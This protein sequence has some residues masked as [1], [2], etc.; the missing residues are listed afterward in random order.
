MESS[1]LPALYRSADTSSNR[2]QRR[3]FRV[4]CL[5]YCL[6]VL[7]A[8]LGEFR[9]VSEAIL[10]CMIIFIILLFGLLIYRFVSRL[11]RKWYACRALA[12]SV[13]TSA[14]KYSMRAHPFGDATTVQIPTNNFT[15]SLIEI[16]RDNALT[17][18]ELDAEHSDKE[19]ISNEMS[20]LRALGWKERLDVYLDKR[21]KQQRTWYKKKAQKNSKSRMFWFGFAILCYALAALTLLSNFFVATDFSVA[22]SG[23]LVI[24]TSSFAWIQVKRFGELSASY[25]LTAHE[26]GS[27]QG[28]SGNVRDEETLS[29]FVNA[30]EFAFSREHTQWAVRRDST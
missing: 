26:I 22:F 4:I 2:A 23:L 7:L 27:I 18:H 14:W 28:R 6:L 24:V 3:Y 21:V 15:N 25:I 16:Q 29:E 13:K 30:A 9:S 10:P 19:Q 12:E 8:L 5:E 17:G 20:S 1:D 11:D